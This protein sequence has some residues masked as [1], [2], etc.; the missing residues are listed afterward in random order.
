MATSLIRAHHA[1]CDPAPLLL[2]PWGDVLVPK[3]FKDRLT[4]RAK[5]EHHAAATFD[6]AQLLD[7]YLRAIPSYATVVLRSRYAEDELEKAVRGTVR[8]YVLVGAGFDSFSLRRPR[9]ADAVAVFEVDH[10]ATQG[11]KMQRLADSG[12]ACPPLT[13]FVAADLASEK[14]ATA[15]SRSPF[16]FEAPSFFSWLGVTIYLTR[17]ANSAA[18][19]A[20]A[21]CGAP[22]SLLVF[23]YTD[24]RAFDAANQSEGFQRM[25]LNAESLGEPFITG[26]D[27]D[28]L[29][30]YL[31]SLGLAIV[32]DLDGTQL[33]SRYPRS[34]GD[35]LAPSRYS[36]VVLARC[37]A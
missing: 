1:R 35:R 2:D 12:I 27:P 25:R 21:D 29:A 26:F 28:E 37:V 20:I 6:E 18:L 19:R 30:P 14:L 31:A 34:Q 4:D 8:Q 16:R 24:L 10:P 32:E 33:A 3:A 15:L 22:G 9:Y 23:T 5:S 7:A 17:E 11:F 13:H 36:H